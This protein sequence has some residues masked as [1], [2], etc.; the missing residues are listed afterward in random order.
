LEH[1]SRGVRGGGRTA[2]LALGVALALAV[3][4]GPASGEIR[5]GV[6]VLD[7]YDTGF[8]PLELR[9]DKGRSTIF[10]HNASTTSNQNYTV[11]RKRPGKK[12]KVLFQGGTVPGQSIA[13][14]TKFASGDVFLIKELNSGH[15]AR[16]VVR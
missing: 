11:T 2:A 12:K 10:I 9:T 3:A 14:D 6:F 13:G 5:H 7:C 15:Q 8:D 16:I 1:V 4:T